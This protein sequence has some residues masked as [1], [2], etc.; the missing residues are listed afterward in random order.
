M[1][2]HPSEE[3]LLALYEAQR[4]FK[5]LYLTEEL[6]LL[7]VRGFLN[8]GVKDTGEEYCVL[9]FPTVYKLTGIHYDLPRQSYAVR[10]ESPE[11]P[12]VP[13]GQEAETLH[14]TIMRIRGRNSAPACAEKKA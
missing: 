11:F 5:L 8:V 9:G 14:I 10:V 1:P 12:V 3:E 2:N 6:L 13:P 7:L 4:Q